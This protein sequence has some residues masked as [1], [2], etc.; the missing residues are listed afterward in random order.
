MTKRAKRKYPAI[1]RQSE[2]P[3]YPLSFQQER[4]LY[5]SELLPGS[6]LWNKISCKR[7]TGDIDPEA[8]RQAVGDL[9][10][11]HTALRTRV[12]YENGAPVQ[13]FDQTLEA[14]FQRIDGSSEEAELQDEAAL[15]K[16]AE[17]CREPIEVS[18][19]PLF[20]VIVLPMGGAGAAECL[21][22]LKLHHIISDE[23][24]FQ[25]LWRDL[26]AF[27]NARMGVIGGEELK[28]LAVDY[29]DYVHWQ[30]ANFDEAHT[31]EQE[32]YWLKQF[33]GE[34]PV[35]DLPTDFQEPAQL[36]F[37]GALEIRA[38][39]GDLVKKLRSLCVRHKVIPFSAL[40]CAYYVL[41]QKCSRQQ[42]VVVGTVFSGRH[43]SSSLAQ[44]AGFFVNTV[45]IRMEVDG[46]AAFDELLKRVHD[47]V[48]EAYYMQDYP[49][50]RLIQKLN[51]ERRS[52]RNPLYRAMFNLVSTAKEKATFAGA[53]E[54]WEE[55]VLDATQVDLL[56]NIHQQDDAMEMR[57]EYNTDL[58][59]RETVR[60]LMELYV[61]L[62][63]KLVEH[64]EVQVKELDMLDPQER[65]K[66]LNEWTRTE[67]DYPRDVCVHELFE[68]QAEKTP[69][70]VALAFGERTMTYG[71]LN[72]RANRLARTL[73][74]HGVTAESVVG[75][76][77]ERSF[78]MMI[79]ILAVLKA[80]GA[81]LPIDP[82]FPEE[83]KR[84][85]L[86]DSGARVLLVPSGEAET[87][88]SGL[89]VPTLAIDEKAEGDSSNLGRVSVPSDL[90][91]ILYTS[92]STGKPKGVMVEHSSLVNTLAHLQRLFPLEQEDAYLL[93]TSFTFDVSMSELFGC[94]FTGGKLVILEP[95]AEKE[96]ARII[97]TI[98]R[99]QVT[100]MNF[101]PSMLQS[102][103]DVAESKEAAPALQSLNY[104]FAAGEALGAHTVQKFYSLGLQASLVN[105]YGPTEA[106]I[107]ATGFAFTGGEELHRVPIGKPIGN[108]RAYI[109]DEHMNLQPVGVDGELCL[110][111][112][113][114]A[115][116]YLNQP[117]LTAHK[118]VDHP[119]CPG[120]KLYRTGDLARWQEDGNIVFR[121][122]IDQQVK[123]RGFRIELEEI[124]KTLLLH[125]S[126]RGAAV[127]VKEDSSGLESLVAYVV[128]DE[129]RPDEEWTGHLGRW[130]PAY[131]VP[132]RYMRLE[133]LPL[134][135]SGKVDRKALSAPE[136]ALSTQPSGDTPVT[137][138]ERKLIE[139]TENILNMQG[140]GVNDNFFRLGG[141]SLLTIR[142][143]TEIESAFQ[144]SLTLMDFI[145]LPVIKDIAKI[146]EPML[147][148]AVP[149]A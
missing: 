11:R 138:I 68:A 117:E 75:V 66:L 89:P 16:L 84:F 126:V 14:I 108:M 43:Y 95:G 23:T 55:P 54:A 113:G 122:R 135:T 22:I 70:R 109:V 52:V 131:M 32:A 139:I 147:P 72:A 8:L 50:E 141:N 127:A 77:T 10:G 120:E 81:Y 78:A 119:F 44:A 69:E 42:E 90:A 24:T 104:V 67:A 25:L 93:K 143:V 96:P 35:L 88:E 37:R 132:A 116:G 87:A 129:E 98:R 83:R 105:L 4:V 3:S 130:L 65:K 111:G 146:I 46:E 56:L 114:L 27:Y 128:T 101:A 5:L 91:Y 28:P 53:E 58:F 124:E 94:F 13:T 29:A 9:I 49:F 39:P 85:M 6:T 19:D 133:K 76:M 17:V 100:H 148:K 103:M 41:L 110:A 142:F 26:K 118:F 136:A 140:I 79:G 21:V 145:D 82:G 144:I 47:K 73:R 107:Y 7:V 63:R 51:P 123:L 149:H 99:H 15:R 57:L 97:E 1:L 62:L 33:Q 40:L 12:S 60:H 125:S 48:D 137:E 61:N 106:T 112:K 71:E 31:Q 45:A 121:G 115:R 38:L 20:Q 36:S 80:G 64:P 34:L 86:E 59:R 134:S 74:D 2:Q 92:G 30:R 18:G 102:F